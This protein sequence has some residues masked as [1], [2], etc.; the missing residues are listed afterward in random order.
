MSVIHVD[1]EMFSEYAAKFRQSASRISEIVNKLTSLCQNSD[2]IIRLLSEAL[3]D[4][5]E[6]LNM[7]SSALARIYDMYYDCETR[8][9][10]LS[11]NESA[12]VSQDTSSDPPV[13]HTSDS[14]FVHSRLYFTDPWL[15]ELMLKNEYE[16]IAKECSYKKSQS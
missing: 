12:A 7:I 14:G 6:R 11:G 16:R 5:S 1:F 2:V 10:D 15:D 13:I 3:A 8:L 9:R 4:D